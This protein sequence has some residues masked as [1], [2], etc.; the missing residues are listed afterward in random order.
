MPILCRILIRRK[1]EKLRK[2]KYSRFDIPNVWPFFSVFFLLKLFTIKSADNFSGL[3]IK[4]VFLCVIYPFS[5]RR[6]VANWRQK[7]DSSQSNTSISWLRWV[8]RM[9]K[10]ERKKLLSDSKAAVKNFFTILFDSDN[11]T[12]ELRDV[13]RGLFFFS[14]SSLEWAHSLIHILKYLV[15]TTSFVRWG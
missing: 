11:Q 2:E 1:F 8:Q 9:D 15:W 5:V 14:R 10:H 6:S 3:N 4:I 12:I 7:R 13:N